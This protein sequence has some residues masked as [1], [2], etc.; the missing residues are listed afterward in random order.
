MAQKTK[1]CSGRSQTAGGSA[2][3]GTAASG[4]AF[5]ER[6]GKGP[7]SSAFA[8][9]TVDYV[10]AGLTASRK[11]DN[12][13]QLVQMQSG[14]ETMRQNFIPWALVAAVEGEREHEIEDNADDCKRERGTLPART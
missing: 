4:S 5:A 3:G 12:G 14:K 10:F 13:I 8:R 2:T 11:Q 7:R 6:Q 9:A 1:T